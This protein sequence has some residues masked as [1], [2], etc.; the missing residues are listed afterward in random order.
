MR[1]RV[2]LAVALVAITGCSTQDET[3]PTPLVPL[4]APD[5][6]PVSTLAP[7]TTA[8]PSSDPNSP[9]VLA[10]PEMDC[11]FGQQFAGGE[12]TFVVADR[13]YGATA[14]GSAIHCLAVLNGDQRGPV[15]WSPDGTRAV[16][17]A[18]TLYD[19]AGT[20][21]SGFEKT[22][23]RVQWEW[24]AA[25]GMF[26]PT[27]T[28]RTLVRRDAIDPNQRSEIT[29]LAQTDA[30]VSH[31]AG[32]AVVASGLAPDGTG[33]IYVATST[34][35]ALRMLASAPPGDPAPVHVT[36]LGVD[37]AGDVLYFIADNG[38]SFRVGQLLFGDLSVTDLATEQAPVLQLTVGPT[39]R[40]VAWKV[41]LC[42]SVTR[43]RVRDDRTGT[44]VEVGVGTPIESLSLA[45]VGWLD[46]TRLVV[47]ARPLGC[48]GPADV[49]IWN[50]L[51]ASATLLVK[52]VEF[53]SVRATPEVAAPL[54]IAAEALPSLL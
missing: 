52:N 40:S 2:W 28:S 13:L 38:T 44:A 54:A 43:A 29:F 15:K 1:L 10:V 25:A 7:S 20:R 41:G 31:T 50:L 23:V 4:V 49:W 22:N 14:D 26:A 33:G 19:E 8:A 35:D 9:L 24:P 39:R 34:G 36:E 18:A 42:N 6:L 21:F 5:A 37:A 51:D 16:L 3:A 12:I 48:D 53:A 11:A 30:A 46:G 27:A 17:N 47:A 32:G 45:P